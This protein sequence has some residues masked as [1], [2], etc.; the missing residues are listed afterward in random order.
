MADRRTPV[1]SLRV[2]RALAWAAIRSQVAYPL[3]FALQCLAQCVGQAIDLVAILVLFRHTTAMGGFAVDEVL[4]V[5]GLAGIAF[6][7]ADM[8]VGQ[9]DGLPRHI[10]EGTLDALL[11]RPLSAL[12]QLCASEITLRRVGRIVTAVAVL[13]WALAAA[14]VDWTADRVVLVGLTIV[15]GTVILCSIW[16]TAASV[17]FWAIE[18]GEFANSVTYGSNMFTAYPLPVFWPWLRR[19][20]GFVVPGAF[21]AYLP[22]LHLLGRDD[23]LGLPSWLQWSAPAVAVAAAAVASG[24]WRLAIRHYRGTGS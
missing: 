1:A 22:A 2:Y 10:R 18:G 15:A 17:S 6:G 20:M 19:L 16:I 8:L 21:V 4:V 24:V 12:W 7:L 14:D 9:L 23:P 3:S 11:L 13:T 5:F